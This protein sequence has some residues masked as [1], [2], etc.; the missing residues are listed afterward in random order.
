MTKPCTSKVYINDIDEDGVLQ[1][2]QNGLGII[3]FKDIVNNNAS[4][5][6]KP[7]LTDRSHIPGITPSLMIRSVVK[8]LPRV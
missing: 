4:I 8:V 1:E 7:N 2:I 6:V 5:F 3:Q